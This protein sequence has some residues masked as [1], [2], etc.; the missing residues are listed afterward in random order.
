MDFGD[1]VKKERLK[2]KLTQQDAVK[3]INEEYKVKLTTAE[4]SRIERIKD[5][6]YHPDKEAALVYFFNIKIKAD[7]SSKNGGPIPIE[8]KQ[9]KAKEPESP[10]MKHNPFVALKKEGV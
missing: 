8:H 4:L 1:I 9:K 6:T 7:S 5:A 2:R 10:E 3:A